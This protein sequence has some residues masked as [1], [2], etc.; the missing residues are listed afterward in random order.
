MP[1]KK[2]P[3]P[4]QGQAAHICVDMQN[5]FSGDSPWAVPWMDRI[6]GNVVD[7]VKQHTDATIFTRFVPARKPGNGMGLK[8]KEY[9]EAWADMTLERL[10]PSMIDLIP[11][12]QPFAEHA[13]VVDKHVYS[14]WVESN[15]SG[16][17]RHRDVETLVITGGETEV[18]VLGTVMGAVDRGYRTIIVKDALCS[19]ADETHDAM[20]KIYR[21]RLG[22]QIEVVSSEE[23]RTLWA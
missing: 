13:T 19:S 9:Y 21:D 8:W 20:M 2:H 15:L 16:V 14:P 11:A 22:K 5:I 4:I 1:E 18:C 7:I 10:A 12:L 23:L 17:L 3:A 6:T